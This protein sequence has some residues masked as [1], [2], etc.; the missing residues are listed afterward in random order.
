MENALEIV[1]LE[2]QNKPISEEQNAWIRTIPN[3]LSYLFVKGSDYSDGEQYK[4]A[5]IADVFTNV[6]QGLC[7]EV[8]V[9][10][11]YKLYVPLNDS[12]GGKR[13]AIGYIPSYYEFYH[14]MNDRMTDEQWKA[15]VYSP[16]EH[17][18]SEYEPFWINSCILP[19]QN[20]D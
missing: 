13:I 16:D 18:I 19:V 10:T 7:L 5:C 1:K 20:E 9:G 6:E 17:D 15:I 3:K 4:M 11:P 12:Q 2:A 8:G 14:S